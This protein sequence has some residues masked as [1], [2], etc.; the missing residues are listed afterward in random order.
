MEAPQT[1]QHDLVAM[2]AALRGVLLQ[3]V[4]HGIQSSGLTNYFFYLVAKR[5]T[6]A[7]PLTIPGLA[8]QLRL[9]PRD[10]E[11]SLHVM[12]ERGMVTREDDAWRITDTG[13]RA[14]TAA[15]NSGEQVL[16][17]IRNAIGAAACDHLVTGMRDALAALRKAA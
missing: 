13:R 9:N 3:R 1:P 6:F 11:D 2:T 14:L 12:L 16:D 5:L 4:E 8:E 17:D 15:N 7:G 10:I